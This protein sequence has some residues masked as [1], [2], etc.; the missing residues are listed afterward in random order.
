MPS[1]NQADKAPPTPNPST[2]ARYLASCPALSRLSSD[3]LAQFAADLK[4]VRYEH[5]TRLFSREVPDRESPLRVIVQ[6][7]CSWNAAN[8]RDQPGA[9]TLNRGD[10]FGFGAINDWAA[11]RGVGKTW[12]TEELPQVTCRAIG[13]LW[14]LEL[15]PEHFAAAF[16]PDV[17]QA[18]R[19]TLLQ[20]FPTVAN[21]PDLIAALRSTAQF[22]RV[23][24]ADLH[25][26]LQIAPTIHV[27]PG[28]P[29]QEQLDVEQAAIDI[30]QNQQQ[31]QQPVP[32]PGQP[33]VVDGDGDVGGLG[34]LGLRS[35]Y[36][37]LRGRL[38]VPLSDE[39]IA[40]DT[41]ELGGPALFP[42]SKDDVLMASPMATESTSVI[43]ISRAAI[44]ARA[45]VSPGFARSLGPLD[46][47][48][49]V[50]G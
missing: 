39:V 49:R 11:D 5:D 7:R 24:A 8:S 10:V 14:C 18:V 44:L 4:L 25:A 6:G 35:L 26:L 31:Q 20:A 42:T 16:I 28:P 22:A 13:T 50:D 19:D 45:R 27:S 23:N 36:Y 33:L 29:E 2:L 30:E 43:V 41:G 17:G 48:T 3:A 34:G 38:V 9:W 37:V 40:L 47:S 1:L 12:P 15:A 46:R 32:L 21:A